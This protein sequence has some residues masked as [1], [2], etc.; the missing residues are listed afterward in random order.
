MYQTGEPVQHPEIILMRQVIRKDLNL[1][2]F[3]MVGA[4]NQK[5]FGYG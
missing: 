3:K 1:I 2:L 5:C 4:F